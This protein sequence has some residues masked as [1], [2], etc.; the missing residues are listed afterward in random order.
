MASIVLSAVGSAVGASTGL[1]FGAQLGSFIG[2]SIGKQIGGGG[3]VSVVRVLASGESQRFDVVNTVDIA[4]IGETTLENATERAVL[5]GANV[6]VLG[7][8]VIQ[9]TT[10]TL[11]APG[12]YRLS[13]L[14]RGRLGTEHAIA[15]H[16]VNERF[17]LM[18]DALETLTLPISNLGV[19]W[20]L[21]A[22][23]IGDLLSVGD[24]N[25]HT[26]APNSLRP[27]TPAHPRAV[28]DV[29]GDVTISWVRRARI[30]GGIRDY[31]DI[32]LI[33]NSEQYDVAV[34]SGSTVL[35]SWRV[36]SASVLY[37]AAQQTTNFGSAPTT[38]SLRTNQL[39]TLVVPGNALSTTV[40]IE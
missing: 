38:L 31:I 2:S 19:A 33:E 4:L 14:L 20:T 36:T 37:T 12:Q 18:D 25:V 15:T 40:S 35:R 8:E 10:A 7:N 6:A 26:V 24:E 11:I 13:G 32:P 39:S 27:Y 16:A 23:T 21:R 29:A 1:P 3:G 9:F 17:V 34:M 28:K 22:V 5:D 30:D